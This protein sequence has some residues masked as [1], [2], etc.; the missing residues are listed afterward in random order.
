M[1]FE[2][3]SQFK[4]IPISPAVT[5]LILGT[6]SPIQFENLNL[7][8][9]GTS[10][11]MSYKVSGTSKKI[12]HPYFEVTN[13]N[14]AVSGVGRDQQ[15]IDLSADQLEYQKAMENVFNEYDL[16]LPL[17]NKSP[18]L[19]LIGQKKTWQLKY[20]SNSHVRLNATMEPDSSVKGLLVNKQWEW[21]INGTR[22]EVQFEKN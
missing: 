14:F 22:D 5:K 6:D 10:N 7:K 13:L 11:Q 21:N 9:M 12:S 3:D 8:A 2:I 1:N 19:K 15:S 18:H 17:I 16:N 20:E 4:D